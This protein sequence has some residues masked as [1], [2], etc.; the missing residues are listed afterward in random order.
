MN[1][2]GTGK[3]SLYEKLVYAAYGFYMLL[4]SVWMVM[5]LIFGHYF[6]SYAFVVVAV[7]GVQAYYKHKLTNLLLGIV[8]FFLSIFS[9]LD[10]LAMGG[11]TGFD[12]FVNV[13][14]G[15]S[16]ASIV[17]SGILIFSYLKLSFKSE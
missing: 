7:F 15:L 10:F 6:N 12:T 13:M 4:G 14:M 9:L 17:M 1:I 5:N 3:V 2:M 11:K 16:F 8:L